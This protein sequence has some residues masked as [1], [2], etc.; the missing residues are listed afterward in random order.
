MFLSRLLTVSYSS[1]PCLQSLQIIPQFS[2]LFQLLN[3][4]Q[5]IKQRKDRAV[6]Q[7]GRV[8]RLQAVR[9]EVPPLFHQPSR[10][11]RPLRLEG[12]GKLQHRM[13]IVRP[14]FP[15]SRQTRQAFARPQKPD[16]QRD[17]LQVPDDPS[18]LPRRS[19]TQPTYGSQR[20]HRFGLS[21]QEKIQVRLLW[22]ECIV[23]IQIHLVKR[24][25]AL[26]TTWL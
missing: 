16:P 15:Q 13:P 2:L 11:N 17:L 10:Q 4:P 3:R 5:R 22:I 1:H 6:R 8:R 24:F 19:A 18:G 12:L 14:I 9:P 7:S 26:S 25:T 20:H 23:P 21:A